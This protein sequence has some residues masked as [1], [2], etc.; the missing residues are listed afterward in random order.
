MKVFLAE[1]QPAEVQRLIQRGLPRYTDRS[2]ADPEEYRKTLQ[3]VRELGCAVNDGETSPEEV[4]IA[5]PIRDH[6][7][8]TVAAALLSAPRYRTPPDRVKELSL[9]V[10]QAAAD[11]SA[12]L[13]GASD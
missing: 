7:D 9:L 8:R 1:A 2:V 6:R 10:K 3:R 11:I 12:R 5:A 4:G 13:G